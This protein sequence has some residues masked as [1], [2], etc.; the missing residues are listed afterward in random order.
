MEYIDIFDCN[1]NPKGTEEKNAAHKKGLWH[2]AFH[3]WIIRPNGK[4]LLQVRGK[5][6][7][8]YP[9][10]LD[11][12]AAGHLSAGEKITDGIREIKEEIG[13]D[14]NPNNLIYLGYYK[15]AEDIPTKDGICYNREFDHVFFLKDK[16]PLKQYK[17]QKEEVDG[18]FEI[19]IK[20]ALPLFNKEVNAVEI[21][22]LARKNDILI[23]ETK[24]VT[25]ADFVPNP[26]KH[27]IK[28][29]IM[30]ERL[31]EGKKYLAV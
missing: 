15:Q 31:L 24:T 26:V 17:L 3:C 20:Q 9:N 5:D 14:V 18:I 4:M 11:I 29:F 6:K 8:T 19:D 21:N 23:P 1:Y 2:Q 25:L 27:Y 7:S 28:I 12:S 30:A 10:L 22:G 13:I 16:T